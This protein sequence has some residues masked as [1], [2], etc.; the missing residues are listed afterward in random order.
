MTIDALINLGLG[1]LRAASISSAH[2]DVE[3]LLAH[4]CDA[5]RSWLHAHGDMTLTSAQQELFDSL[6]TRR[7]D[8]VPIAYLVGY[9]DFYGRSFCVTSATLVPRPESETIISLLAHTITPA[10]TTLLD[11]GTGSGCLGITAKLEHPELNVTVSDISHMALDVARDNAKRLNAHIATIKSNLLAEI[12][13]T[14][15]III[16]NLPYVD[17][18][19]EVSPDTV[20]EPPL[21]LY[22]DDGGMALIKHLLKQSA[23][24]LSRHGRIF[25]E[26]DPCQHQAIISYA[27]HMGYRP[28]ATEGYCV[29][30][31]R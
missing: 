17:H 18:S 12:S 1:R 26:A 11:V 20:H 3:L 30:L 15:D 27:Q 5:D 13:G 8:R 29:V 9:R 25:L 14:F 19:W 16:A 4:V 28:H 6:V 2:L 31:T 24:H 23:G 21:A 10:D 22:A 7:C